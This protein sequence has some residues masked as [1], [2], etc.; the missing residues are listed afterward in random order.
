MKFSELN[1]LPQMIAGACSG[2]FFGL[3]S[4]GEIADAIGF[5]M[6]GLFVGYLV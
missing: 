6:F 3:M 2:F 1:V 4:T 5:A